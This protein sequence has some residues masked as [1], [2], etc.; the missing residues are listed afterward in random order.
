[1]LVTPLTLPSPIV[2]CV[3]MACLF[4]RSG[5]ERPVS[6]GAQLCSYTGVTSVHL[7]GC[8][9]LGEQHAIFLWIRCGC[10]LA[11]ASRPEYRW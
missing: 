1:M 4:V 2:C 10:G 11:A 7:G 3:V 8:E 9:A 5:G 6:A